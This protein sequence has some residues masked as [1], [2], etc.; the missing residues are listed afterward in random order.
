MNLYQLNSWM[1]TVL[2]QAGFSLDDA[3][4][5]SGEV[6]L[7]GLAIGV[8]ASVGIDRWRPR[9]T[10]VIMFGLM[11]LSFLAIGASASG[12]TRWIGLLMIGVGGSAAGGM[13]LPALCAYL[14]PPRLLSTAIGVGVMVAR[15]GAMAGPL[16]G[17]AMVAAAVSP[18]LFFT[19]AAGPAV[20]CV[21]VS[22]AVPLA[23]AVRRRSEATA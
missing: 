1:P 7:A 2:P 17:G 21:L 12:A 22:L 3:A 14:F 8:L 23:L 10:L 5:I 4:R 20:L 16:L 15:I 19:A 11:A 18:N 6:Q 9:P 13:A